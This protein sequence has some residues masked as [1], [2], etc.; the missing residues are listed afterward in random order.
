MGPGIGSSVTTTKSQRCRGPP[1]KGLI[2]A[3]YLWDD[4]EARRA[5][6]RSTL[7]RAVKRRGA[8]PSEPM[9]A[10]SLLPLENGT[11][12]PD[13][14]LDDERS[15]RYRRRNRSGDGDH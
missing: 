3:F 15:E 5:T 1:T 12:R 11:R 9:V 8:P 14:C 2:R 4:R 7:P 6:P 10:V 13:P